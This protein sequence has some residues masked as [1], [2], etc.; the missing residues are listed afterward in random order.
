MIDPVMR[1]GQVPFQIANPGRKH[2]LD[3]PSPVPT[4]VP[5]YVCGQAKSCYKSRIPAGNIVWTGQVLSLRQVPLYVC[6]QAKS[7][8]YISL[9]QTNQQIN[10]STNQ[11]LHIKRSQMTGCLFMLVDAVQRFCFSDD[12]GGSFGVDHDHVGSKCDE[13]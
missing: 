6:G 5:L 9:F 7:C 12:M 11:Q 2:R 3:R 8:P 13:L 10:K 4:A 1:T